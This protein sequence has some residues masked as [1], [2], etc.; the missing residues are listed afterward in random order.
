[1]IVAD[2][3]FTYESILFQLPAKQ[4]ELLF[5]VCKAGKAEQVTS[6]RFIRQYHL[7]SASSVQSALRGLIEKEFVSNDFGK[8]EV[9][10]KFFALWLKDKIL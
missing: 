8:Y 1:M 10:D 5:A 9:Y 3:R 6:T 4:K 2:F 7:S